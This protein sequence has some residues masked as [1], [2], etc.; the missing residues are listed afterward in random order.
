V[1][2]GGL[3]DLPLLDERWAGRVKY[4][5]NLIV[6][7]GPVQAPLRCTL[8][9]WALKNALVFDRQEDMEAYV[10]AKGLR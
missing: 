6:L 3:L 2:E 8:W 7:E 1:L 10:E 4:A 5:V 9:W